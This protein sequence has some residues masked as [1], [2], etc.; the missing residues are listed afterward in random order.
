MQMGS[1]MTKKQTLENA[2][3]ESEKKHYKID[4][5]DFL[6]INIKKIKDER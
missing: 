2:S 6:D 1:Q 3:K 4:K 5:I